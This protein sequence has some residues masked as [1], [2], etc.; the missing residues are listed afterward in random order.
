M[1][2]ID[3]CGVKVEATS[4]WLCSFTRVHAWKCILP[5]CMDA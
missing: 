2:T 3:L 5:L 1:K 4:F